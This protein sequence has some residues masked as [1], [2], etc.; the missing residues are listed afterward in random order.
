MKGNIGVTSTDIFPLIKKFMYND[1]DIFIREIVSNAVDATQKLITLVNS[2]VYN[3]DISN[4]EINVII[5]KNNKTITVSDPGIGMTED[6]VQRYINQI[7]FSG[8]TDFLDKYKNVDIIG[9]FGLG[10]YS[11]FMVSDKVELITKSYKENAKPVKWVCN[12]TID[13][14]LDETVKDT[15]GT[16]VVMY[17]NDEYTEYLEYDKLKNL[18]LKYS[19][20]LPVKINIVEKQEPYIDSSTNE[21]IEQEDKKET[22]TSDNVLWV[23]Q[24]STLTD[25]D[26]INFYKELYPDRPEPLFWI[27]L[28]IDMPFTFTGILYFPAFD[29]SRPIFEQHHLNLYS[30]RVFV[31]DDVKDILPDYLALL[32]G[33]I[34]SPDIPLN[35]SRS[36]LQNDSNVKKISSYI[37]NKVM[38]ALRSLLRKDRKKYEEKWDT[39]KMFINLGV[40]TVPEVYEKAKDIILLT[41]IDKNKFTFD[42]YY[43]FVKDNQTDKDGNVVYLYTYDV[44]THYTYIEELKEYGYNILLMN[45]Q[46][47]AFEIQAYET[48][49]REQ[50]IIYKRIDSDIPEKL[51]EKDNDNKKKELPD[52]L[53]SM[54]IS[55]FDTVDK[56]MD[57]INLT[58]SVDAMGKDNLPVTVISNE[59][60][61][62][63]KEMSMMNNRG[64]FLGMDTTLNLI[65]NSDAK[66]IKKILKNAEKEISVDITEVNNKLSEFNKLLDEAKEEEEKTPIKAEIDKLLNKKQE[67]IKNYSEKD[68]HI[69]EVID[70]ALLQYGLLT[71]ED[72]TKFIKRSV[73]LIE[74]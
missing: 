51:I 62:R 22:I 59:F 48:E 29:Q 73:K 20:F 21:T 70:I 25:E 67:I 43:E 15:V 16:D 5:D 47:S 11:S 50:K 52:N 46:Y 8:A 55:L 33:V 42:E 18:L 19:K 27:H 57:K 4:L 39:I 60:Y 74:K 7:A 30:N 36:F 32:H 2:N 14:E 65:I 34:D 56:K 66:V 63:M 49:Q 12:G 9:H 45:D 3:T 23:K 53:K 40:I 1:Q 69:N 58:Y 38:S 13:F 41:D 61:R 26:Y 68:N 28:N 71:G 44:N 72:L 6:E 17:I 10:F 54:L 37:T 35:V 31:T 64:M 24:P